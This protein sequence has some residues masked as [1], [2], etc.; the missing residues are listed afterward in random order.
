M[1]DLSCLAFTNVVGSRQ[2][3]N[4]ILSSVL[5]LS[6]GSIADMSNHASGRSA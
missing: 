5:L 4:H 1:E 2:L 6:E 3:D